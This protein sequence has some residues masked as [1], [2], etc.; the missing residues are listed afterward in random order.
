MLDTLIW[1]WNGTLMD[2]VELCCRLLNE[3]LARHGYPPVGGIDAYKSIFGFPIEAYYVRAGF[4]FSRTPYKELA[5]EYMDLYVP[6]S[7]ACPMTPRAREVLTALK[8]RGVRQVVLSASPVE[9]LRRQA[10][11]YGV[12][13]YFD[14]LLGLDDV[15]GVSKT[16]RGKLWIE[17]SGVDPARTAMVGDSVHDHETASALGVRS[18]LYSGGHQ[19]RATLAATGARVID[20]LREL[21]TL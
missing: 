7:F 10:E 12:T 1:D 18:V 20:D 11:H 13:E 6:A 2:D 9:T 16:Q 21:L 5:H 8:E 14:E 4:D 17:T 19:P 3:L 15:Y